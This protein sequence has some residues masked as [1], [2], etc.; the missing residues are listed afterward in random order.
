MK[1]LVIP[2][3]FAIFIVFSYFSTVPPIAQADDN[4]CVMEAKV[5]V[6]VEV[7][8]VDNLGNKGQR[9]F[10]GLLKQGEKKKIH[11]MAGQIRYARTTNTRQN[12]PLSGDI[13]RPCFNGK[14]ISVP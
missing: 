6:I 3:I 5:D 4:T 8:D 11:S 9:I 10:K 2:V 14:I 1:K 7:W 13:G 12:E